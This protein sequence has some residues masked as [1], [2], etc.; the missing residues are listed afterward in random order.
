M[1]TA[2][3][4]QTDGQTKVMNRVLEQYLRSFVSS[5]PA[6][7]FKFLAMAEWSYNTSVHSDTGLTPYEVIYGKPPPTFPHYI[8]GASN[9]EAVNEAVDSLLTS[10]QDIHDSL[11]RRLTKAQ[12]AMKQ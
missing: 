2:Y 1:S 11:Q 8:L 9:N 12:Q 7:W 10:R 6:D 4:P 5:H 3:H